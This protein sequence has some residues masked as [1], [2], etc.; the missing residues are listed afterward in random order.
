MHTT[1]KAL[2]AAGIVVLVLMGI[3]GAVREYKDL[4][5]MYDDQSGYNTDNDGK[6]DAVYCTADAM[7]CSDGSYVGR[8]GADCSFVCPDATATATSTTAVSVPE[9]IV[10]VSTG[11]LTG[12]VTLGPTCPVMQDPPH[13]ECADKAY[14]TTIVVKNLVGKEVGRQKTDGNGRFNFTLLPGAYIIIALGG[15]VLPRCDS[16]TVVVT[17]TATTTDNISCD[18]GIR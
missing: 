14:V 13:A 18:T 1:D 9:T 7:L 8:T 17:K 5:P 12:Q 6:S 4:R 3:V 16:Q 2:V 11:R 15:P 10:P